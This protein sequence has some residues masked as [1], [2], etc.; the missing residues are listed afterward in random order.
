MKS[1]SETTQPSVTVTELIAHAPAQ[2]ELRLLAGES[3][4]SVRAINSPRIQ[5]LG[6]ALAGF[7]HYIHAGRIQLVGQ[8]EVS[9]LGQLTSA[10]RREAIAKLE[11]DKISCVLVSKGLMPPVEL[12]EA[13]ESA[14]LPL[15]QTSLVS[16]LAIGVVA[17][18]LQE[19]LA[20]RELRH[21]ALLDL[22]GLGV[23][24][25]GESGIGKSEC[26]LDLIMRGHRLVADDAV[27]VRRTGPQQLTGSAPELLREHIE[28][29]GLGIL[30]LREL[31]GVSAVGGPKPIGLCI[32]LVRWEEAG[33]I[34]R[35]GLDT[36]AVEILGVSV[37]H[38]LLPVSPGRN[39]S[40]LVETAVRLHLSR[41]G[42]NDPAVRLAAR[43]AEMIEKASRAG[44][45]AAFDA[46]SET[47]GA[48]K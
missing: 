6:L 14:A 38:F 7:T 45:A 2:L 29:R 9:Y 46:E 33:E 26:A 8:S 10:Q 28:I 32:G 16:S 3:G 47:G 13:A 41:E 5:K 17:Q 42:G 37:P 48:V 11:L 31:F 34:E 4:A 43:H 18:Y 19:A 15:V 20:P 23:L 25:E 36:R 35:L 44:G 24:I 21:G 39:L 12:I 27:D 1:D 40:T 22:Y 30:N